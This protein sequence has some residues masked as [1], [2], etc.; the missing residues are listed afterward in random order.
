MHPSNLLA[1]PDVRVSD[2]N[3][4]AA[5]QKKAN[6]DV[7][8]SFF[9][10]RTAM[11][12]YTEDPANGELWARLLSAR[13]AASA[14]I[15]HLPRKEPQ[16]LLVADARALVRE[17][18]A[19]G[20]H[21]RP[22]D[23]ADLAQAD[24]YANKGWQGL[25]AAMLLTSAWQWQGAPL[26][27]SAPDWLCADY[28]T[29]LFASPQGFIVPGQTETYAAHTLRR[30]EEL[31]RWVNRSPDASTEIAVLDAYARHACSIPLY[32]CTGNLR[33]HAELRGRLLQRALVPADD[34]HEAEARPRNG[35][36]L[37]VGLVNRH[38]G[39]Q[40]ETYGTLPNFEQ[41]DPE[42]F[43]LILFAHQTGSSPLEA[44]C[45]QH[46]A[47]FFLLP[48]DVDGQL[49]MLRAAALDI[50]VFGTN[51]T[52]VVNEVT[53][54]ALYRLAPLQVINMCS[55]ITSGLPEADLFV[56]GTLTEGAGA[57]E[58]YS[59]R[60]GL[61]P[62][63]AHAFNYSADREEPKVPCTRAELGIPDQALLFVS[64]SNYF[65]IIPEMQHEWARLLAAVP[66]SQLLVH[67]FNPNWSSSYPIKRF[68]SEFEVV[69]ASHGVE[70]SRLK[71]STKR[72]PSRTDVKTLLGLGDIY[73]DTFP[74]GG[75]GSLV[76]PL[77]LGLPVVVWDGDTFRARMGAALVRQLGFPELVAS[78][79]AEYQAIAARLA[80]D[81]DHRRLYSRRI[82]EQ[83]ERTPLFLDPLGASE[84]FGDVLEAAYDELAA[85]GRPAFR[86]NRTPICAAAAAPAGT[87]PINAA[88]S[89][90]L[91]RAVLRKSPADPAARHVLGRALLDA[92]RP[93]RAVTYLLAAL[94]GEETKADL[95]LD[96]AR[97]LRANGQLNEAL[98]ALEA[99]LK[100]DQMQVEGWVMFAEVAHEL[101]SAD[102]AREAAGV[103]RQLAPDDTR[104]IPFL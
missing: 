60:L 61:V 42:R 59:E 75:V 69:L 92:G 97:A 48:P 98:Q 79:P 50:V 70:P 77:E 47:D 95:W 93:E 89:M 34:R 94:Q 24:V 29:W 90:A 11:H 17:M 45:R 85:V 58:N 102:I 67:P 6:V 83:M 35:R 40:T 87:A 30:L 25:L 86:A 81:P 74:F 19:Q 18:A 96:V 57:A 82:R 36:R 12:D 22:V 101:G 13:R 104:V 52:A 38:F 65:K 54:L 9:A 41:L 26:L 68:R 78:G 71:V 3:P 63:P 37:R 76:D 7:A 103:V 32:F 99:G 2:S 20:L 33:R 16:S 64:G 39:P 80:T 72:F 10:L 84:V 73:L 46:A 21:D 27:L 23:A 5:A 55:C 31:V 88:D 14:V 28:V 53:R 15:S 56:S 62:G 66:N 4:G 43:E 51:V 8:M 91:A 49:A 1:P 100:V 44:Y